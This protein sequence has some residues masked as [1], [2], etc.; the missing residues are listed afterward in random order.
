MWPYIRATFLLSVLLNGA[1]LCGTAQY[2]QVGLGSADHARIYSKKDCT[3]PN[4]P[5][6]TL[7][8]DTSDFALDSSRAAR[9]VQHIFQ[10]PRKERGP[11]ID[12]GKRMPSPVRTSPASRA[13]CVTNHT[14]D[15]VSRLE[16]SAGFRNREA[17][18][19]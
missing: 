6:S 16:L 2:K 18:G 10:L 15:C 13:D 9:D 3:L 1:F 12:A 8:Q 14:V 19:V 17:I 7:Q 11:C 5:R 4:L